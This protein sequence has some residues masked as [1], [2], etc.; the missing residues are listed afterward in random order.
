MC[1]CQRVCSTPRAA[2]AAWLGR[3]HIHLF[4]CRVKVDPQKHCLAVAGH[5]ARK[6]SSC[7]MQDN[8]NQVCGGMVRRRH[9]EAPWTAYCVQTECDASMFVLSLSKTDIRF[10][11]SSHRAHAGCLDRTMAN[12]MAR[13]R[14]RRLTSTRTIG[15]LLPPL[16]LPRYA[17]SAPLLFR[18]AP[19]ALLILA[20]RAWVEYGQHWC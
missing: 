5:C 9:V 2:V 16:L 10:V 6:L 7:H 18:C 11:I 4:S 17:S 19:S 14:A 15:V 13:S 3:V 8:P 1:A 20:K 12:S